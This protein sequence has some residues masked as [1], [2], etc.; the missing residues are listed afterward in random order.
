MLKSEVTIT[1]KCY[2]CHDDVTPVFKSIWPLPG[3]APAEIGFSICNSC[4]SVVQS[5]TVPFESMLQYYSTTAVY[6]NPGRQEQPTETKIRD[7]N[8]QIQFITRGIGYLPESALQIG[9]SDGYTLSRFK[10]AGVKKVLGI[11][12]SQASVELAKRL[13]DIDSV[14]LAVENFISDDSFE[15]IIMTHVLEHLYTPHETLLKCFSI[16][17]NIDNAYIYVEV[18]L[19]TDPDLLCPGFFAFEHINYY[20]R[21]S[22]EASLINTGYQPVSIVEHV[23]SN[24]SPVIGILAK[25]ISGNKEPIKISQRPLN[26][27]TLEKYHC[28]E[29]KYWASCVDKISDEL[30][31]TNGKL[32]LWGAGIHTCHLIA[33]TNIQKLKK[34]DG[35]V[36]TSTLKHGLR[37]GHWICTDPA[38][39]N[40]SCGDVI[41][42]S[43][44]A[45][46]KEIFDS[47][48][49]L[50]D[51]GVITLRLHNIDDSKSH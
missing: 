39:I 5:P 50:R 22:L 40:W 19:M 16:Q 11:E 7:L 17:S 14:N 36:D 31:S 46:E 9:S 28:N 21:A 20:T 47:L 30:L 43:S 3:I 10:Q 8:E 38:S 26:Q 29:M 1:R 12:P 49:H 51:K 34:I 37:Q 18:P 23:N 15:L 35:I 4:G 27:Q 33:N 41:I 25:R 24:L 48:S 2:L 13:Y 32:Y 45:S 44:Y 6:T 42:I